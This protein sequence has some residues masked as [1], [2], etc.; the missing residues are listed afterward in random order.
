MQHELLINM[1][2][3]AWIGAR[4]L[5]GDG[6]VFY[7]RNVL[8]PVEPFLH[9]N[10]RCV[11]KAVNMDMFVVQKCEEQLP[12]VCEAEPTPEVILS[13]VL[14]R[15]KIF[16]ALATHQETQMLRT[17]NWSKQCTQKEKDNQYFC[18]ITHTSNVFILVTGTLSTSLQSHL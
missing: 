1:I 6:E 15:C 17:S 5:N 9:V 4:G 14:D 12:F 13:S 7:L 11:M 2:N 16:N 3:T 8:E 10:G 18:T